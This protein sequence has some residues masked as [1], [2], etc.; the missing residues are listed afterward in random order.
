MLAKLTPVAGKRAGPQSA[1]F[2][3]GC[4]VT[5]SELL[6]TLQQLETELH[7]ETTRRNLARMD[8][9]L[10]PDFEEFGRSGRRFLRAEVLAE[11]TSADAKVPTIVSQ[12]FALAKFSEQLA[13]LTYVSAHLDS[14]GRLYRH[15]LRSSLWVLTPDGWQ[16]RFHQGTPTDSF[17]QRAA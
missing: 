2:R 4:T 13:L 9:L 15:T 7:R 8:T 1:K 6:H 5:D 11:F 3:L 16:I 17:S 14:S 12:D 10:H